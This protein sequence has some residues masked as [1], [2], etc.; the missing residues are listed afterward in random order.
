VSAETRESDHPQEK[1]AA[2][3]AAADLVSQVALAVGAT[4]DEARA[5]IAAVA[6]EHHPGNIG[7]YMAHS[8][9]LTCLLADIRRAPAQTSGPPC[10]DDYR[11]SVAAACD[12]GTPGGASACPLCRRGIPALAREA[13]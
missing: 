5:L 13:G 12:H 11:A 3:A 9:D 4:P 6:R 8:G 7:R 1:P 2:D 10:I